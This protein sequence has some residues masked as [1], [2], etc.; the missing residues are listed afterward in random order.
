MKKIIIAIIFVIVAG[1]I[2]S[3]F[4]LWKNGR[5][6]TA[7]DPTLQRIA[8]DGKIVVGVD[9][10]YGVMEFIDSNGSPAGIDIDMVNEI[11]SRLG[12]KAEIRQYVWD[13]LFTALENGN[14][15]LA[16]S[17][18]TITAERSQKMLFSAPYFNSGQVVIARAGDQSVRS[19]A[20]LSG[21]M[22]GAQQ[23]TT[24]YEEAKKLTTE[25]KV[26][27]YAS[28]DDAELP[29]GII[30]DLKEGKTDAVIVDYIQAVDSAKNDSMIRIAGNPLTQEYY[31]I[32]ASLKNTALMEAVDA[33]LRDL[34]REGVLETIKDKW[35]KV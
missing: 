23:D 5:S 7:S 25:D 24:G 8:S 13:D 27:Q 34:K 12:V 28:W 6:T 29:G 3:F 19:A 35:I 2:V 10:P 21:R 16:V 31:G 18:I 1:A 4:Y 14:I 22:V 9:M 15:D 17:S 20:D 11:A 30:S 33:I 26:R 32:A